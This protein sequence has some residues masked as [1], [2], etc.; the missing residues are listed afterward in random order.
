MIYS[1]NKIS[2]GDWGYFSSSQCRWW[3]GFEERTLKRKLL[4]W[5]GQFEFE[6][7]Y[8]GYGFID[9][10]N[11]TIASH[12]TKHARSTDRNWM[13]RLK[14]ATYSHLFSPIKN[15]PGSTSYLHNIGHGAGFPNWFRRTILRRTSYVI[16]RTRY[17]RSCVCWFVF[18]RSTSF[19]SILI[20]PC[21]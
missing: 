5:S 18:A 12:T 15:H 1:S 16:A 20:L 14:D 3:N 13:P 4:D 8:L 11:E 19:T 9:D 6:F 7:H 21:Q 2:L 17:D 10:T